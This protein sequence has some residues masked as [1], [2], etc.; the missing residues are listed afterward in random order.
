MPKKLYKIY[1]IIV[2]KDKKNKIYKVNEV[3]IIPQ[4]MF[5]LPRLSN[6]INGVGL[7]EQLIMRVKH[8][9]GGVAKTHP[10]DIP[11]CLAERL[12]FLLETKKKY[13]IIEKKELSK[14]KKR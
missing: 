7:M 2:N 6:G 5:H 12:T 14:K 1:G 10:I 4:G 3:L 13:I 11:T 9:E 8:G